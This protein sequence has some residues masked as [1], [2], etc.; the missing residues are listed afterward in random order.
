MDTLPEGYFWGA[1]NLECVVFK[2]PNALHVSAM[3]AESTRNC[4]QL[5]SGC[6]N[7]KEVVFHGPPPVESMRL[8][9]PSTY[10][11]PREGLAVSCVIDM[12]I[13]TDAVY[14]STAHSNLWEKILRNLNYGGRY[15]AFCGTWRNEDCII[16]NSGNLTI[17]DPIVITN[18]VYSITT[19]RIFES[20]TNVVHTESK[21]NHYSEVTNFVFET[22]TNVVE[23]TVNQHHYTEVTNRIET[24][25]SVTN[26]VNSAVTNFVNTTVTNVIHTSSEVT[27]V[28]H[29]SSVITNAIEFAVTNWG[30][31]I[32]PESGVVSDEL[33]TFEPSKAITGA[34]SATQNGV[35]FDPEGRLRG[36]AQ[37]VTKS[38]A[39]G[40][41]VSGFLMLED[42]KKQALKAVTVPV[43]DGFLSARTKVGKIG[44]MDIVIGADGFRGQIGDLTVVSSVTDESTGVLK[45]TITM[46]Y[47]TSA[48]KLKTK[49]LTLN[50]VAAEGESLGVV[51]EK[52]KPAKAYS[53]A[54]ER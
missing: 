16:P 27:N 19:N 34:S 12:L 52:G 1:T 28:I 30:D 39:K 40:V 7:L 49:R 9:L 53:A 29:T 13:H 54:I 51:T 42:G 26:F 47:F 2:T 11:G 32:D 14:Y 5:F 23:T 38:S 43:T 4:M 22:V 24:F 48:N 25:E 20:V 3:S 10:R 35:V 46:S 18:Y 36:L 33:R 17:P 41:K 37:V 8:N 44:E 15:G 21:V 45:G 50:G 6:N 31:A